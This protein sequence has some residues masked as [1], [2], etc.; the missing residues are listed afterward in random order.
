MY[1]NFRRDFNLPLPNG[2]D[3]ESKAHVGVRSGELM[4]E[5]HAV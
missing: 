4:Y 3:D 5:T 2:E 1:Q